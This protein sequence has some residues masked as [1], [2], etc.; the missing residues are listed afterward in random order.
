MLAKIEA[1]YAAE[2][3]AALEVVKSNYLTMLDMVLQ[4]SSDAALMS[5]DDTFDVNAYSAEKFHTGHVK[6]MNQISHMA[7]VEDKDD[8]DMEWT[9]D[10]VDRR[11]LQIVG[12]DNF[13]P[14]DER[15]VRERPYYVPA[16]MYYE[17]LDKYKA[18]LDTIAGGDGNGTD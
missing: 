12:K 14:W 15:Y 11:M 5:A 1:K 18:L 10:T 16:D 13:A 2:Y 7:I 17:L 8:D 4:Q 9:K 6:Y 3:A